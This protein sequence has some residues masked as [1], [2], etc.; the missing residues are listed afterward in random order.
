M[1][2]PTTLLFDYGNTLIAFGPDQQEAQAGAMRGV[3]D[4]AGVPHDPLE[5]DQL[6]MEQVLRPYHRDGI[7]NN[8][9]EVCLEIAARFAP[10]DL[11]ETLAEAIME[12][13]Q[14]AFLESVSVSPEVPAMLARLKQ[15]HR[16]GLL[17]NYPCPLSITESLRALGLFGF[18][19]AVVVS[20]E[21]GFAKPH[22]NAY[23]AVL[24]ALNAEPADC[25]FIGDNWV[26]DIR[27]PKQ[28]GMRTAW[29]REHVPYET[30]HPGEDDP[31]ADLEL[32][33][34]L[35]LEAALAGME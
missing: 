30:F 24:T 12:A 19:D 3:L 8:F 26:A 1:P 33:R 9:R 31:P 35:D 14:R 27:G 4:A 16:L 17:S 28:L 29:I 20:G 22:R 18:F 15:N 13:R 11:A 25:L 23:T 21:V 32:E 5:L 2:R 6:R 34:L 7:E 10:D